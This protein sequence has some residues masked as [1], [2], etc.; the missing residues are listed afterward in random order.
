MLR[1]L[2]KN[3]GVI[4]M[5]ILSD[6][7]E[8]PEPNPERDSARQAVWDKHGD[9]YALDDKGKVAFM[10]DWRQVD[11][12]FPRKLSNVKKVVDHIDHIVQVAGIDHV[13]IG[14]DFDGGG[15][16]ADCYDV[17]ELPNITLE[18]FARGYSKKDVEKIWAGNLMRV[19]NAQK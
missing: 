18:L 7:V 5:C 19:M 15:G 1:A 4:Q 12:D 17:S 13:G 16:V 6:Y 11:R 9:Y 3:D 8:T 2:A 14:T 10:V